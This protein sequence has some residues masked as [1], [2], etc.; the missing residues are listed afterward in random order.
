MKYI[1]KIISFLLPVLFFVHAE[2]PD[3]EKKQFSLFSIVTFKNTEC[4]ATS[5]TNLKGVCMTSSECSGKGTADGNCAASFGVCCVI[6]VSTC[7]GSVSQ[8]CSYIENPGY[9]SEYTTTG[10]CSYTVTRCQDDICQLR[11]DFFRAILQQPTD[12]TGLC[13]NTILTTTSGSTGAT[14]QNT[15]PLLCGTLTDQHIYVDAGTATT[16][17]TL[18]FTL[19][20]SASN[21]WRIKVSQIECW[22]PSRAP[23]GCLQYFTGH[24][25]TVSSFN[26]DG[27]TACSTG[28]LLQEMDYS[29]CYRPEAGMC[30]VA[31][32]ETSVAS[33]LDAFDMSEGKLGALSILTQCGATAN[34]NAYLQ[35]YSTVKL[36]EDLFCGNNLAAWAY[37]AAST[38][39]MTGGLV[40]ARSSN[41][42][43]IKHGSPSGEKAQLTLAGFSID[44]TQIP[45]SSSGNYESDDTVA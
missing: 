4:D 37:T 1:F 15:P 43:T 26:W 35:I 11:L 44:T 17:A 36:I 14:F 5:T 12:S 10:D 24:R 41:P 2:D 27:T 30:T 20:S 7:G 18:K 25:N 34:S 42:W 40:Y 45:C 19:A 32:G 38:D 8:N 23:Q 33:S 39:E 16:A 29:I 28:C 21:Y 3:R 22:N 13:T 9:P 31:H 6:R